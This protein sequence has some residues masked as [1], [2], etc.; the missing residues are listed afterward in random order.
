MSEPDIHE[1]K[2]TGWKQIA[3]F[4]GVSLRTARDH[5]KDLGLPVHRLDGLDKSRVWAHAA[6]LEA[7]KDRRAVIGK[8]GSEGIPGL[9]KGVLPVTERENSLTRRLWLGHY[10]WLGASLAGVGTVGAMMTPGIWRQLHQP[11]SSHRIEGATLIVFGKGNVELWRH[12]FPQ[13]LSPDSDVPPEARRLFADLD[14]D[15]NTETLFAYAPAGGEPGSSLLCFEPDGRLRWRFDPGRP[16]VID[17]L[18]RS[19]APPYVVFAFGLI[20]SPSL[21]SSR[22][23]VSSIHHWS[24]ADQV[25]VLDGRTGKLVSEYWHRGHLNCLAVTD[26]DGDGYPEVLLGGVNDAPEYKQATL[27]LFDNRRIA[28]SN[29]DPHGRPYF[30]GMGAGTE[31]L[32][33]FFPKTAISQRLEFNRVVNIQIGPGRVT[34]YVAEGTDPATSPRMIYEFDYAFRPVTAQMA[35]NL[36]QR[37]FDLQAAGTL[38][39]ESPYDIADRLLREVKIIRLPS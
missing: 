39:E 34:V 1:G 23:V 10:G 27:V 21:P 38:P 36:Q 4:L 17:N 5:E 35:G 28:G 8:S 19:F 29:R 22:V 6:E 12:T 7:W 24:F 15:G 30:D 11:A 37:Y 20:H 14:Q 25:A 18:G 26:L 33:V 32:V 31:K 9:H 16:E 3:D 13:Q 2:L